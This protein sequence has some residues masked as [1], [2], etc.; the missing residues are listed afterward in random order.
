M[1]TV[2]ANTGKLTFKNKPSKAVITASFAGNDQYEAA[3]GSYTLTVEK[4]EATIAFD[5]TEATATIGA[6]NTF[7]T[8]ANSL[9]LS[10]TYTSSAPEVAKISDA[11]KG[12]IELLKAGEA[13]ITAK[14]AGNDAYAAKEVSYKLVVNWAKGDV[15]A[16]GKVDQK[17]VDDVV[18]YIYGEKTSA[19]F[20]AKTADVNGD[21]KVNV[22]DVVKIV[23]ITKH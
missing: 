1:A 10:V 12:T 9:N 13:T 15:N 23:S 4:G 8:L 5:K 22:A 20:D 7:P 11:A 21:G 19:G 14:F 17:D 16:D 18:A 6:E 2:D 3:S